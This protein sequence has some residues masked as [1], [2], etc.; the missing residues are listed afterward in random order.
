MTK[1][2]SD[3]SASGSERWLNC[4]GSV[5]LSRGIES[6]TSKAAE[7]GTKAHE[8]LELWLDQVIHNRKLKRVNEKEFPKDMQHHVYRAVKFIEN[9]YYNLET[10]ELVVEEKLPLDFID[11]EMFG[12]ADVQ[13][14]DDF[15]NL[16]IWDYK[17]GKGKLVE[18]HQKFDG[19]KILNTQLVYYALA[20]ANKFNFDFKTFTIGVMQPRIEH[21]KGKFRSVTITKKELLKYVDYFKRGVERTKRKRPDFQVGSWCWFCP[22]KNICH[23]QQN[24][25][26][27]KDLAHFDDL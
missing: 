4:P 12:T 2:H 21:N 9:E 27:E 26:Y 6:T 15:I 13:I 14:I 1:A 23:L 3:L 11:P 10:A 8:L 17:H 7:E 20:A 5:K 25:R 18:L 16:Q 19:V 22:A 24:I